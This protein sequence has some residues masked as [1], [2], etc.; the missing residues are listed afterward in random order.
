MLRV[1]KRAQ[2]PLGE[3]RK[4]RKVGVQQN[5]LRPAQTWRTMPCCDVPQVTCWVIDV[6]W[7]CPFWRKL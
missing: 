4:W 7:I 3:S 1:W 6:E 5:V 2:V